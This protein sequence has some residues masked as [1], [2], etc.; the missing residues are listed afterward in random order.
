MQRLL[1][2]LILIFPL[3]ADSQ[4]TSR[5]IDQAGNN[6]PSGDLITVDGTVWA[7]SSGT[8]VGPGTLYRQRIDVSRQ[9]P[10]LTAPTLL[11]P[12]DD[13]DL[14][15]PYFDF[16][17]EPVAGATSYQ[18]QVSL[19][20]DFSQSVLQNDSLIVG[21]SR[22]NSV[23]ASWTDAY[24]RVRAFNKDS[25]GPWSSVWRYNVLGGEVDV[26]AQQERLFVYPNPASDYVTI[27][28][29]DRGVKYISIVTTSGAVLKTYTNVSLAQSLDVTDLST[30]SYK[31]LIELTNGKLYLKPLIVR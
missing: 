21:T 14:V 3:T 2:L 10:A 16:S 15:S 25:I 19:R 30:G 6:Q 12:A 17:W 5:G 24:W 22:A 9:G 7:N 8:K 11:S 13:E 23:I 28:A 26:K 29:R 20:N 27:D 18:L 1:P 31:L 4:W